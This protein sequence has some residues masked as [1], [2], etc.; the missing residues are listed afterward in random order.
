MRVLME[1]AE[2][3]G[4]STDVTL[5]NTGLEK[6]E[7]YKQ[8]T[9]ISLRQEVI[10]IQ[11][12]LST[13]DCPSGLGIEVGK[14]LHVNAFG[15]WGFALLT[16]P[17]VRHAIETAIEYTRISFLIA[18]LS[19]TTDDTKARMEFDLSYLPLVTR[20]YIVERHCFVSMNFIREL[21]QKP[22]FNEFSIETT[23]TNES[24]AA[25]LSKL[26]N[27]QIRTH[28]N[29]NALVFDREVLDA[30]LPKSDPVTLNYCLEQCKTLLDRFD[31]H[32]APWSQKVR[33][34]VLEDI[35]QEQ[36]IDAVASK[37]LITE[38]TLRRRLTDENTSFREV[39]TDTRLRIAYELLETAKLNVETVSWR[40]GY[41]EPA[42]FVRA[43][44]KRFG[45]TPGEIRRLAMA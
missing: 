39:Y 1:A 11:N 32:V 37:L 42:S 3:M 2:E 41:S 24:Y 28:Q 15:I 12:I 7:L 33:D 20:P 31:L 40:V 36:K 4:V 6:E 30:P 25:A 23:L 16:S 8:D 44:S 18:E 22:D 35:T 14:R 29:V 9:M 10:A 34:V 27:I 17:T 21:L 45:H 19:I 38:R 13:R 43:F 5:A 26:L